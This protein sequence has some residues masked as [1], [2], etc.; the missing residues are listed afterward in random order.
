M[1][2]QRHAALGEAV[3]VLLIDV[4]RSEGTARYGFM[5]Q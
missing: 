2:R 4:A 3:L 5:S 1:I